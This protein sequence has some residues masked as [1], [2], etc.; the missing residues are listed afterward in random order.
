MTGTKLIQKKRK[1]NDKKYYKI[2]QNITIKYCN[3]LQNMILSPQ[4]VIK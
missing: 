1:E 2:F 4:Q 3:K